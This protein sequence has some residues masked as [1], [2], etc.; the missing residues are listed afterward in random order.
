MWAVEWRT[1]SMGKCSSAIYFFIT[2]L[3][4]SGIVGIRFCHEGNSRIS[5][6]SIAS[7]LCKYCFASSGNIPAIFTGSK[8]GLAAIRGY[9]GA[10]FFQRIVFQRG[11]IIGQKIGF[12]FGL[13]AKSLLLVAFFCIQTYLL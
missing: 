1:V 13:A 9:I 3:I 12:N 11:F 2:I 6:A 7:K 8:I 4:R 5:T 10:N